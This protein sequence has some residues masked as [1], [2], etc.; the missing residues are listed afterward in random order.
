MIDP[1]FVPEG[2][3][4]LAGELDKNPARDIDYEKDAHSLASITR[5]PTRVIIAENSG[6]H[7]VDLLEINRELEIEALTW[8]RDLV[9][10]R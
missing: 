1:P 3:L 2:M 5:G 8:V 4:Y 7:G 6:E 10:K 9:D